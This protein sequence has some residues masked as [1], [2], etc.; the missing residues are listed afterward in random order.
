MHTHTQCAYLSTWAATLTTC[1]KPKLHNQPPLSSPTPWRRC[2]ALSSPALTCTKQWG[3][4]MRQRVCLFVAAHT[5]TQNQRQQMHTHAHTCVCPLFRIEPQVNWVR[6]G[7]GRGRQDLPRES[8]R[9]AGRRFHL[10]FKSKNNSRLDYIHAA[11]WQTKKREK[12]KQQQWPNWDAA[13][14]SQLEIG[15]GNEWVKNG[16]QFEVFMKSKKHFNR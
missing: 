14:W 4:C 16:K 3:F 7:V 8:R 15:K 2:H 9:L 10:R 13:Q 6:Q 12:K 5:R 11:L 1:L